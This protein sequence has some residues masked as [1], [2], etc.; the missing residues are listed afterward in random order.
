MEL[1]NEFR[2]EASPATTWAVLTDLERIAPCMPGAQLL[3]VAGDEYRGAVKVKVGP[4][5]AQ[6]K[7]TAT[8]LS[9]DE[10]AHKA[11]LK[12][13]GR[14]TRGQGN[15]SATVTV[16][17]SPDGTGTRATV[18]T[19][20]HITGKVAQF[21]RGVIADVS[22]NLIG[23]FVES[24]ESSI[25][26]DAELPRFEAQI[27]A[28]P[29]A[30]VEQPAPSAA[31]RPPAPAEPGAVTEMLEGTRGGVTSTASPTVLATAPGAVRTIDGAEPEPVDLL[32]AAGAPVLKRL[33]PVLAV[34]AAVVAFLV[35][36][37]RR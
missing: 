28:A 11:V 16:T 26:S 7:G 6:Y 8:F 20:L 12:A 24:L 3:E 2:V 21:G 32:G 34:A 30:R 18:L 25:L 27:P 9:L 4:V 5:V 19:D 14:E 33:A 35:I 23:K 36:L 13:D 15:A 17:L 22:S 37:R 31:A 1:T 10:T 29:A